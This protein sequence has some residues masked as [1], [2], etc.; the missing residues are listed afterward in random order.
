MY[1]I[2]FVSDYDRSVFSPDTPVSYTNEND[3]H[4]TTEILF[5]GALSTIALTHYFSFIWDITKTR[6]S[7]KKKQNPSYTVV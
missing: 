5:K 4:D 2:K 7:M 6:Q 3:H 1:V